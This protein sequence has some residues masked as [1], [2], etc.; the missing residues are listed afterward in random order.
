MQHGV[1]RAGARFAKWRAVLKIADGGP[2][3]KAIE[4]NAHGLAAYAKIA[5]VSRV[6]EQG[7]LGSLWPSFAS[8]WLCL[9]VHM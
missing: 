6:G 2:S 1:P 4:S 9:L 8:L 7:L 3:L 5:Q